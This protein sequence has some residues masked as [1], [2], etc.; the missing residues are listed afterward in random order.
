MIEI[1]ENGSPIGKIGLVKFC[2]Y[3]SDL[4]TT[5]C[6]FTEYETKML[7]CIYEHIFLEQSQTD[8]L[9]TL[10]NTARISYKIIEKGADK[11]FEKICKAFIYNIDSIGRRFNSIVLQK[12][13]FLEMDDDDKII[14]AYLSLYKD[15]Y[16]G[17]LPE[18]LAPIIVALG[19][20]M[21]KTQKEFQL[22]SDGRVKIKAILKIENSSITEQKNLSRGMNSHL[23][24]AYSHNHYEIQDNGFVKLWDTADN[25]TYTWGPVVW[26]YN[27]LKKQ[28]RLIWLNC[29]AFFYSIL[30]FST[31]YRKKIE[32]VDVDVS[33][34]K[35][36]LRSDEKNQ[37]IKE[38]F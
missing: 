15:I 32:Q 18:I 20:R 33:S 7:E 8:E 21:N 28:C 35:I 27:D 16:E 17:L 12:N 14:V 29:L 6:E 5:D 26:H 13:S 23:R 10:I 2:E 31:N 11:E 36:I 38:A 25:G 24:N 19:I 37:M 4:R 34:R 22:G 30:I 9:L 3:F 1:E